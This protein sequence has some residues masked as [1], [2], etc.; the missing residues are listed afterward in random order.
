MFSEAKREDDADRVDRD[1]QLVYYRL[2]LLRES[3]DHR[4]EPVLV[5]KQ[6]WCCST[7]RHGMSLLIKNGSLFIEE[8][9]G[10][11][12]DN[13]VFRYQFKSV[14]GHFQLIG[15]EY[16]ED[17]ALPSGADALTLKS[18]SINHLTHRAIVRHVTNA[19]G[20]LY[21]DNIRPK[22]KEHQFTFSE[23][24]IWGLEEFDYHYDRWN[25]EV[26]RDWTRDWPQ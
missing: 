1:H 26:S 22:H 9:G 17:R 3:R 13:E 5:S 19:D 21:G 15:Y 7:Y 16:R 10:T 8:N 23:A 6:D 2:H 24:Q 11:A 4:V 14:N 12:G 20:V 18:L 25:S